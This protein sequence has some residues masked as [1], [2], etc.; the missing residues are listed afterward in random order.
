MVFKMTSFAGLPVRQA[1]ALHAIIR[2]IDE[3]NLSPTIEEIGTAIRASKQ[4]AHELVLELEK[5]GR[6]KR[7]AKKHRSIIVAEQK[8]EKFRRKNESDNRA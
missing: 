8:D 1:Q 2:L 3:T 5:K 4:Q 7:D 6:I